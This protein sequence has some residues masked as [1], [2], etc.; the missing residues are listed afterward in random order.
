MGQ[1]P[2]VSVGTEITF[3]Q[4]TVLQAALLVSV[5]A[6]LAGVF[7]HYTTKALAGK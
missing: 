7:L 1:N 5:L 2:I 6:I 3:D 4:K